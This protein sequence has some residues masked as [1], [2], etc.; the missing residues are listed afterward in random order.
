MNV[1][2]E[3]ITD[4]DKISGLTPDTEATRRLRQ[5][6]PLKG[7]VSGTYDPQLVR[8]ICAREVIG[9]YDH[10]FDR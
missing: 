5:Y 9:D 3:N 4:M 6:V 8:M 10:I 1:V 2:D 7:H